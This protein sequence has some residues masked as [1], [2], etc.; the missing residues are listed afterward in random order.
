MGG[1]RVAYKSAT[2]IGRMSL[3]VLREE[4]AKLYQMINVEKAAGIIHLEYQINVEKELK[5][6]G[7]TPLTE[8]Q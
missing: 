6:R 3:D 4:E 5:A 1:T 8:Q 7:E 2:Q